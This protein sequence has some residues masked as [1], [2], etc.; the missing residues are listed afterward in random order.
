MNDNPHPEGTPEYYYW[1][2]DRHNNTCFGNWRDRY[3]SSDRVHTAFRA[4]VDTML[5]GADAMLARNKNALND[6]RNRNKD[7]SK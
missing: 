2:R 1:E 3:A 5:V 4:Y 7:R 6:M